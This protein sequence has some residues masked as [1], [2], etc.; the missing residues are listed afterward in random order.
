MHFKSTLHQLTRGRKG[1]FW[2]TVWACNLH[3]GAEVTGQ[4]LGAA[5]HIA[6]A[7]RKWREVETGAQLTFSSVFRLRAQLVNGCCPC[8]GWV[9]TPQLT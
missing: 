4:E 8:F 7:V 1:V 9:F 2:L 3:Q 6:A 5:E